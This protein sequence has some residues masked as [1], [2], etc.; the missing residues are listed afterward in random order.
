[1][2]SDGQQEKSIGAIYDLQGRR[3][4]GKPTHGIYIEGR[5]KR[6]MK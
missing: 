4:P 5:K 1:M 6:V 2:K 3:L